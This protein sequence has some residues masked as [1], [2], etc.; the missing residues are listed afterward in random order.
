MRLTSASAAVRDG[1]MN[2]KSST[3]RTSRDSP[4]PLFGAAAAPLPTAAAAVRCAWPSLA[5]ASGR[6]GKLQRRKNSVGKDYCIGK[7]Y[8]GSTVHQQAVKVLLLTA[9]VAASSG[10]SRRWLWLPHLAGPCRT[11]AEQNT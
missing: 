2:R 4:S 6:S 3:I 8:N 10:L 11:T 9:L 5:C 1:V 7:E